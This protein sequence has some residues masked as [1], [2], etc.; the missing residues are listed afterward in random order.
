MF[1]QKQK[2]KT[3]ANSIKHFTIVKR[4]IEFATSVKHFTI[5]K[6]YIEFATSVK[7]FTAI[8]YYRSLDYEWSKKTSWAKLF[9]RC[10]LLMFVIG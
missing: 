7:H 8:K 5:V 10:N 2:Q 9:T 1:A 4:Y 6:T 3:R